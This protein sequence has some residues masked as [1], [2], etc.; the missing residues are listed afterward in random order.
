MN[1][2]TRTS[3][4]ITHPE[5]TIDPLVPVPAW[6][7]SPVGRTRAA[8]LSG[9]PWAA[10]VGRIVCSTERKAIETAEILGRDLGLGWTA[11]RELGEHDR[12]AT[13][14]L[15]GADYA[16]AVEAFFA[17]PSVSFRGWETADQ[18]Q[19]RIVAAV[20]RWAAAADVTT[21][22]VIHGGVGT[23]LYCAL[24]GA[25][26]DRGHDQPGQGSWYAF[27]PTAWTAAQ[28]WRRVDLG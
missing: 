19:N 22:Y 23:L 11:D 5:V 9:T 24:T 15:T 3:F 13:G 21:A 27:D 18:A 2:A 25:V 6:G 14:Y 20:R 17:S 12:S 8:A 28:P 26:I 4:V 16:A 10:S 7:L 1:A